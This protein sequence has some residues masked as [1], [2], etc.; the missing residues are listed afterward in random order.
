MSQTVPICPL[1][2]KR[3]LEIPSELF[4]LP[5]PMLSPYKTNEGSTEIS[6]GSDSIRALGA[7][8]QSLSDETKNRLDISSGIKVKSVESNGLFRKEGI[9]EGFII[10]RINNAP[11]NDESDVSKIVTSLQNRQDKVLLIADFYPPNGRTQ[12]IAIN[13][14]KGKIK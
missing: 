5:P 2:R 3:I 11:V 4:R 14:T 13:L 8:F 9:N 10:M 7:T 1:L 12:Y 6:R